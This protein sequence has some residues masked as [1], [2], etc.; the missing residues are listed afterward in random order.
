MSAIPSAPKPVRP[1]D[2][3]VRVGQAVLGRGG[4]H[5]PDHRAEVA[6]GAAQVVDLLGVVAADQQQHAG[7]GQQVLDSHRG[8]V[9]AEETVGVGGV[10]ARS[11]CAVAVCARAAPRGRCRGS[12]S[13]SRSSSR[14]R[15]RRAVG[16]DR[17]GTARGCGSR[18][19]GPWLRRRSSASWCSARLRRRPGG[20]RRGRCRAARRRPGGGRRGRA[21]RRG[22]RRPG[23]RCSCPAR[24]RGC[25][26]A[27]RR[28]RAGR[29]PDGSGEPGRGGSRSRSASA[30]CAPSRGHPCA[31]PRGP[32]SAPGWGRGRRLRGRR[33]GT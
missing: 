11:R 1:A 33:R 13:W 27:R 32:G 17:R 6:E 24:R 10:L 15:C 8:A 31:R 18:P 5:H 23:C 9:G 12:R 21:S 4:A 25:G 22:W 30:G 2:H 26:C 19:S 3:V 7:P 14:R 28:P 20:V 16:G 29:A